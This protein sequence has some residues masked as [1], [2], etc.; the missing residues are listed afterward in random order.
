MRKCKD[1]LLIYQ[2]GFTQKKIFFL[3]FFLK[4]AQFNNSSRWIMAYIALYIRCVGE[5]EGGGGDIL[6]VLQQ[7]TRT[8]FE[9]R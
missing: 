4:S 6:S 3:Y 8:F 7:G 2:N 5:M 9:R 1:I